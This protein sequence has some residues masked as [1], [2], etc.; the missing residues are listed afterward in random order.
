MI[1]CLAASFG[2]ASVT[3]RTRLEKSLQVKAF[4]DR[5]SSPCEGTIKL[6]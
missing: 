1:I 4:R 3:L 6:M 5:G 2:S